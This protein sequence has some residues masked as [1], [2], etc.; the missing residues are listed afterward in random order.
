MDLLFSSSLPWK[1]PNCGT[2]ACIA[3]WAIALHVG[4]SPA[5]AEDHRHPNS[6]KIL[7][8]NAYEWDRLCWDYNW[9]KRF[10]G[11]KSPETR[12]KR[13]VARIDAFIASKGKI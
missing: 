12:A 10:Q 13:A 4:L 9:P 8:L 5:E 2:A 3:G 11:G 7:E 1:I 6:A